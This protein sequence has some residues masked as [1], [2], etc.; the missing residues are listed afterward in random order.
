[1]R[2]WTSEDSLQESIFSFHHVGPEAQTLAVRE[3]PESCLQYPRSWPPH[4][5]PAPGILTCCLGCWVTVSS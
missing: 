5:T 2:L 4:S 1:M 3:V